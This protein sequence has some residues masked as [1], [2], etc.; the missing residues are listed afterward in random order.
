M[1][2]AIRSILRWATDLAYEGKSASL[3]R[4]MLLG[5]FGLVVLTAVSLNGWLWYVTLTIQL[6]D[7][8]ALGS[9]VSGSVAAF[10]GAVS[11]IGGGSYLVS[12]ASTLA[13]NWMTG[14]TG[15]V[16]VEEEPRDG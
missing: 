5:T 14:T 9:A 6:A 8:A 4:H 7:A 1:R 12:K 2:R 16:V 3:G 15:D 13:S 10:F 11:A